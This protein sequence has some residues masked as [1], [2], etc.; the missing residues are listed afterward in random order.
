MASAAST[1]QGSSASFNTLLDP[2]DRISEWL[3]GLIMVLT[4][5]GAISVAES[6]H[7]E[8]RTMMAAAIGC[9]LA[10]GLVDAVMYLISSLIVRGHGLLTLR[11]VKNAAN[12]KEAHRI[13]SDALPPVAASVLGPEELEAM[14]QRLNQLPGLPPRP[15]LHKE[16][17]LG[18]V[19]VFLWVFLSTFPVVM[20]FIFFQDA[21][22]ALRV[23]NGIA[24]A[25]LF[26][27]GYSFGHYSGQ[28]PWLTGL[29]MVLIGI[30]LLGIAMALGG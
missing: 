11:R 26:W 25:M 5:T 27:A 8:I 23:S 16:D 14:R 24:V 19:A 1:S 6:G 17:W 30:V 10:W 29:T 2:V 21:M 3:F 18:A 13:I 28:R 7:Q 15:P 20:P 22:R 4:F 12:P 9:N